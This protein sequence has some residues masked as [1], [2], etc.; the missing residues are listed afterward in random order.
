VLG[1]GLFT[2][3]YLARD[4]EHELDVVVRVLRPELSSRPQLRAE[5]LDLGR[6]CVPLVHQNLV[7][8]RETCLFPER[9][10]YCVIRKHIEGTTLRRM[11]E[12]GR[13]FEPLQAAK[14]LRQVL[15]GL[16]PLHDAGITH[17]GIK[18]SNLFVAT[19]DVIIV[20]D[21]SPSALAASPASD[22]LTYDFRYLPPEASPGGRPDFR[23]DFYA[24]GCVAYELFCGT[25]PFVAEDYFDL[26]AQHRIGDI[27]P[28][29]SRVGTLDE[30]VDE[31]TRRF[32]ARSPE[33][34]PGDVDEALETLDRLAEALRRG[35]KA[36]DAT[37]PPLL[38]G[39]A[40]LYDGVKSLISFSPR[41]P[42]GDPDLLKEPESSNA[43]AK[44]SR[45]LFDSPKAP[46]GP[47]CG[48]SPKVAEAISDDEDRTSDLFFNIEAAS[49]L[50]PG[51]VF[52]GRYQV[53]RLLGEGGMGAVWLVR[54]REFDSER[55]LKLIVSGIAS[56]QQARARFRREARILDKLNH[57]NAVR[58]YDARMGRGAA[59]LIMEY[60]RGESLN[61]L[62]MPGVPMPMEFTVDL[63]DQLCDVLQAA[64]DL[65]IIHRDLKP[66][67]L[68]LVEGWRPGKKVLKLLDFGLAK[69]REGEDDI[70]TMT[71]SFIGTPLYSSPEQISLDKVDA[72][73]DIYSVGLILYELLTGHRPFSGSITSIIYKHTM[74]P[75]PRF[76]EVNPAVKVPKGVE[77]VVMKCLAKN[78]DDRPQAP[79]DLAHMF[80]EAL[81][82]YE[83]ID[84]PEKSY[85][86]TAAARGPSLLSRLIAFFFRRGS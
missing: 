48:P 16:R 37:I 55:A 34:R 53:I 9:Q 31:F 35:K 66:P 54:D 84:A 83:P 5:F 25:P 26:I 40:E 42:T 22:R 8:T 23:S 82:H 3:A 44:H 29:S 1:Q 46:E 85:P 27:L 68:M 72:R 18:P 51:Q 57:P 2:A 61:Q 30:V 15:E 6:K 81:S 63:L 65:G 4:E 11:L 62:L 21:P 10:I 41:V 73:S 78:P 32:L 19:K 74:S 38:Q 36:P 50:K 69:I 86:V 77:Q 80:H 56:D 58:V 33:D 14:I 75:P 70:R 67:N 13:R 43:P 60:V 24:L 64:N 71:G 76:A 49:L 12:S 28:P 39:P 47:E 45:T 79:R 7:S 59:F 20:G 52:F 17:G